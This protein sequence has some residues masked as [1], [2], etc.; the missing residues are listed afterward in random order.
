[1]PVVS[2]QVARQDIKGVVVGLVCNP[3]LHN[4]RAQ[5]EWHYQKKSVVM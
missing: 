3:M 2:I 4:V 1:M 5:S